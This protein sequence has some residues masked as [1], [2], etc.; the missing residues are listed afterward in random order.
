MNDL[1]HEAAAGVTLLSAMGVGS[2]LRNGRGIVLL[3]AILSL[4]GCATSG[5]SDEAAM[6]AELAN[7]KTVSIEFVGV[8]DFKAAIDTLSSRTAACGRDLEILGA[9]PGADA[10]IRFTST[11]A[12]CVRCEGFA[13]PS[14]WEVKITTRSGA[15]LDMQGSAQGYANRDALVRSVLEKVSYLFCPK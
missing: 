4:A 8:A 13:S 14:G 9:S 5:S 3:V 11:G 2:A 1:D 15:K 12:P 6:R 7:V 10:R